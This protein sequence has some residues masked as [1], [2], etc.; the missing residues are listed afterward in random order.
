RPPADG[1]KVYKLSIDVRALAQ[2]QMRMVVLDISLPT[3]FE[4]ET[5]DLEQ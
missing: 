2:Q 1:E 5:S 4:P 3:G